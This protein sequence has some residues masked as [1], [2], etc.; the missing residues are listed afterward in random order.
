MENA[1]NLNEVVTDNAMNVSSITV[2][3]ILPN[4]SQRSAPEDM[5][6]DLNDLLN[7]SNLKN[8]NF[9]CMLFS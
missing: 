7:M 8:N 4:A 3:I 1:N 9:T 5:I 6:P 2:D